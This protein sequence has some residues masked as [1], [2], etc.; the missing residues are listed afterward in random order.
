MQG[1]IKLD[2]LDGLIVIGLISLAGLYLYATGYFNFGVLPHED[3]AILM[4]Y[5]QHLSQGHG[6]V[7]N[8]GDKPVD[9]G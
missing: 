8:I 3:A 5:S 6:I 4:R 7:W 9:G 2:R 1:Q